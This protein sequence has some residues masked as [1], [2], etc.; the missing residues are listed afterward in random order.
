MREGRVVGCGLGVRQFDATEI[1]PDIVARLEFRA[2]E[3]VLHPGVKEIRHILSDKAFRLAVYRKVGEGP[4][5][6]GGV[7]R[8][9]LAFDV[10]WYIKHRV[11]H[12]DQ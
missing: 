4:D 10:L 5:R 12:Q 11:R 7:N 6:G 1:Q 3:R 9:V 8:K 2:G